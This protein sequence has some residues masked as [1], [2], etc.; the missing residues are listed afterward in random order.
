MPKKIDNQNH[1]ITTIK[2]ITGKSEIFEGQIKLGALLKKFIF[3]SKQN[4]FHENTNH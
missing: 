3:D 2:R 4:N 1:V